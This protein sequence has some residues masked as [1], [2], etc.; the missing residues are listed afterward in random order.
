M[1]KILL[2][3]I[4]LVSVVF[5]HAQ[6][7]VAGDKLRIYKSAQIGEDG[8]V[9]FLDMHGNVIKNVKDPTNLQDVVTLKYFQDNAMVGDRPYVDFEVNETNPIYKQARLW[10]DSLRA[11]MVFYDRVV[12]LKFGTAG[13]V[14][15]RVLNNSGGD[16]TKGKAVYPSG[17]S[18]GFTTIELARADS[19]ATSRPVG[20]AK[21]TML[22]GEEGWVML[23]GVLEDVNTA[24]LS[25]GVVYLSPTIAGDLVNTIPSGGDFIIRMGAIGVVDVANGI[26]NVDPFTSE[27]TAES[28]S[29]RGWPKSVVDGTI[30][31]PVSGT[32]T[33]SIIGAGYVYENGIKYP[34]DN[35]SVIWDDTEGTVDVYFDEGVLTFASNQTESQVRDIYT[36]KPGASRIY[37]DALNDTIIFANDMRHTFDMN[38]NTWSTLWDYHKCVVLDGLGIVDIQT[39]G[40][41]NVDAD[42]QFGHGSG[43]IRN[44]DIITSIPAVASTTGYTVFYREGTTE[45]R[46]QDSPGFPILTTGTGRAAWNEDVAGTWQQT[47]VV[48]GDFVLYHLFVSN[49]LGDK[50]GTVMGQNDYSTLAAA[51]NGALTEVQELLFSQFPIEELAPV[52]T[53]IFE[54]RTNYSNA[55]QSRTRQST[56][57]VTGNLVDF[58]DWT[59]TD[60][61]GGGGGGTGASSFDDLTDTPA[62]K[63]GSAGKAVVVNGTED[64]LI[65]SDVVT[66]VNGISPIVGNHNITM[67]QN[68]IGEVIT[69]N[70]SGTGNSV[71]I[72]IADSDNVVGNEYQDLANSKLNNDITV[73]ISD[74]A[75]TTI[76]NIARTDF[77]N[78]FDA[79]QGFNKKVTIEDSGVSGGLFVENSSFPSMTL[80]SAS[81]S[82]QF[83][84]FIDF[85]NQSD[86]RGGVFGFFT[87]GAGL[88]EL[89][90][91][92]GGFELWVESGQALTINKDSKNSTFANNV[93]AVSYSISG[94]EVIDAS[95]NIVNAGNGSFSDGILDAGLDGN[96]KIG[97][98]VLSSALPSSA[99]ENIGIGDN[100]L[101][102]ITSSDGN[103]AIGS[104][105][106]RYLTGGSENVAIGRGAGGFLNDLVTE[107]T[108]ASQSIYIGGICSSLSNSLFQNEIVIGYE[109]KGNGS[110]TVSIGNSLITDNYFNGNI[111]GTSNIVLSNEDVNILASTITGRG[112]FANSDRTT[113]ATVYGTNHPTLAGKFIIFSP[114]EFRVVAPESTVSGTLATVGD[115]TTVA[116]LNCVDLNYSGSLNPTSDKRVKDSI[117]SLKFDKNKYLLL[118]P[119]SSYYNYDSTKTIHGS[120]LAQ[121]LELLYPNLVKHSN[122]KVVI[123]RQIVDISSLDS[124]AQSNIK[125][126]DRLHTIDP[127]SIIPLNTLAT[128]KAL[129][130]CDSLQGIIDENKLQ[131][132]VLKSLVKNLDDRLKA[133]EN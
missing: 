61:A 96:I 119:V 30:L 36:S 105:S 72:N 12:D 133:L 88:F 81:A 17:S 128:Q 42:A 24:A 4:L 52:A 13:E 35:P 21:N 70:T 104:G 20:F 69:L 83:N 47:E 115:I 66:T 53:V 49:T 32:R 85:R 67:T 1:K 16:I 131:I 109:A 97:S 11:E 121:E 98:G 100:I 56:D 103:V 76:T 60:I 39:E 64:A 27:Y 93:D 92:I 127:M 25:G 28:I 6:N 40:T 116:D 19:Y 9:Y 73:E 106:L 77:A 123:D 94:T 78:T 3:L 46:S 14:S 74:G 54:T 91:N 112:F 102:G 89:R 68:K 34:F 57:P 108:T 15:I 80:K 114:D 44:Q 75:N 33:F 31:A 87:S 38:G 122:S 43:V 51:R 22:N 101:T 126:E 29:P 23:K 111:N 110:N 124:I 55:V 65:Y 8:T 84:P 125:D 2:L 63:T 95:R 90:N 82:P 26:I 132:E 129:I 86:V 120:F 41:G 107:K 48:N 50:T 113:Y 71:D 45:W 62:V 10:Y 7:D 118:N 5:S 58:I 117:K 18:G 130:K 79:D 37:W 59:K 99:I